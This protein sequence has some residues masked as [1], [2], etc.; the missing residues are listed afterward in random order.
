MTDID[1]YITWDLIAP[2]FFN[3]NTDL[4]DLM[5]TCLILPYLTSSFHPSFI[6][7]YTGGLLVDLQKQDG[8][9]HPIL[10]GE[11]WPRC[12]AS[13]AVYVT[14][15]RNESVKLFHLLMITLFSG[16][17]DGTS[18]CAKIL[19]VWPSRGLMTWRSILKRGLSGVMLYH[20]H[21]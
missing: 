10:C 19:S 8:G 21:V 14:S 9:I 2:L 12:F 18:H 5:C 3:D 16:I 4:H 1:G 6:E 20:H 17:R 7:E 13:L 15:V 11:I